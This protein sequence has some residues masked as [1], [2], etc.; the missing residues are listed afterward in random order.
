MTEPKEK[1]KPVVP[2]RTPGKLPSGGMFDRLRKPADISGEND[3]AS[4]LGLSPSPVER[5]PDDIA[6][7]HEAVTPVA[8]PVVT[9]AVT[10]VETPVITPVTTPVA[11]QSRE[12]A[13]QSPQYLDATHA[14]SEQL[15]YSVMY[16]ET[17]TRGLTERNFGPKELCAKTGIRSDRTIRTAVDGLIAKLSVEIVSYQTGNPLGP[18]YRVFEPKEIVARRRRVGIEIDP[19]SKKIITPVVTPVATP[20]TTGGENYRGAGADSTGVTGADF[21]GASIKCNKSDSTENSLKNDDEA[22]AGLLRRLREASREVTG[23]E[24]S[25]AEAARWN[26]VAELLATELRLAASRT[27]VSSAPAFLAEH[28]RRRLRKA[29]ARQI[30]REVNE[31]AAGVSAPPATAKPELTAE[32]LQEQ[33]NLMTGLLRD[34]AT[35]QELEEHFAGNFRAAQW[36]QIRSIALAQHGFSRPRAVPGDTDPAGDVLDS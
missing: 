9:P 18:R 32:E 1:K 35:I 7:P 14:S 8:T 4:V 21:A 12:P 10:A 11:D 29:D 16:R 24:T 28:L 23:K 34:G 30:E 19:Q 3:V 13:R 17:I 15:I 31:A 27:T 25:P 26:D 6:Q 5:A 33:A 2:T 22:F 36:H 20:A